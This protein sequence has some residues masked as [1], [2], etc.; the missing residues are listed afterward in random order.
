MKE[1][2]LQML[3]SEQVMEACAVRAGS[4]YSKD[5]CVVFKELAKRSWDSRQTAAHTSVAGWM[6]EFELSWGL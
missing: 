1:K 4:I 2:Q 3:V 6:K 5:I